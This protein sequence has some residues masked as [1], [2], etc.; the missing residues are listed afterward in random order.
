MGRYVSNYATRCDEERLVEPTS[1]LPPVSRARRIDAVL[2][3]VEHGPASPYALTLVTVPRK[4]S[5]I[6]VVAISRS[7]A[8]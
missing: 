3:D 4:N 7:S 8:S 1:E 2:I 5:W 6:V